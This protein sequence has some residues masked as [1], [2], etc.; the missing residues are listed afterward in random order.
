MQS[1]SPRKRGPMIS[2][3]W[4]WVPAF[5]RTTANELISR[6]SVDASCGVQP[7]LLFHLQRQ[8][9]RLLGRGGAF[10]GDR[11]LQIDARLLGRGMDRGRAG[12]EMIEPG[13]RLV[14]ERTP[15]IADRPIARG[16]AAEK[17]HVD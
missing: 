5:A 3:R 8:A 13:A 1:S 9:H 15:E 17:G 14:A 2:G 6:I 11:R 4:L 16:I 10:D 12:R 7:A